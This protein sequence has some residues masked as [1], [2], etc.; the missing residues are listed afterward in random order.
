M[1]EV[2]AEVRVPLFGNERYGLVNFRFLPTELTTFID[3]GM[4]WTGSEPPTLGSIGDATARSPVFSAGVG[5]RFNI[6]NAF[7]LETWYAHPFQRTTGN[8]L[9]VQL[10]VGW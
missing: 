6:F 5:A 4:A 3:G 1:S 8:R 9:G 7:I 2:F 10:A